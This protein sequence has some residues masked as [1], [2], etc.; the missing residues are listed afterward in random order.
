MQ[1]RKYQ[2][3]DRGIVGACIAGYDGHRGWLYAVAVL[4][5]HRRAGTGAKLVNYAM[6]GLKKLGCVKV[7]LQIRPSNT[8][9]S[10]FYQNLGFEIEERISMGAF[11]D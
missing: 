9:V 11:T 3:D 5:Q 1:I 10:K 8:A 6:Q 7:N 2:K 4:E